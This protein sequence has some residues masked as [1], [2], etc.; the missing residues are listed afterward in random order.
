MRQDAQGCPLVVLLLQA[1]QDL[2][3]RLVGAPKLP[4]RFGKSPL[5]VRVPDFLP[6][7]AQ[8][9]AARCRGTC[10]QTAIGGDVLDAWEAGKVMD[11]VEQHEAEDCAHTGHGL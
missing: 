7:G 4:G 9:F 5:E 1:G 11:C 10:D 8:A 6:R 3:S 2:V